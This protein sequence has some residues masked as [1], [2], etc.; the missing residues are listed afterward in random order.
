MTGTPD[1]EHA[2]GVKA[3]EAFYKSCCRYI[4]NIYRKDDAGFYHGPGSDEAA[5]S[6]APKLDF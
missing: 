2:T 1:P 4:R 3:M 5:A 6:G